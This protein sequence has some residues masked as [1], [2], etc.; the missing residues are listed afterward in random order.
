MK[1][2]EEN[3]VGLALLAV[4]EKICVGKARAMGQ[5]VANGDF[6]GD[7]RIVESEFL[8]VVRDGIVPI[9]LTF[10][11]EHADERSGE[12]FGGRA[13]GENGLGRDRRFVLQVRQAKTTN[14]DDLI[15]F[16]HG[17]RHAGDV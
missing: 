10:V 15:V 8:Q 7:E 14:E 11:N 13:D 12:R 9:E 5:E 1:N 16:H 17:N 2:A 6:P 4:P 3:V